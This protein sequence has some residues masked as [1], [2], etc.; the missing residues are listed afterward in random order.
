M[1]QISVKYRQAADLNVAIP[2]LDHQL[3]ARHIV[4][5]GLRA[6]RRQPFPRRRVVSAEKRAKKLMGLKLE[7]FE[8]KEAYKAAKKAAKLAK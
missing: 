3:V 1:R 4:F 2:G 6:W 5:G 8:T 7:D